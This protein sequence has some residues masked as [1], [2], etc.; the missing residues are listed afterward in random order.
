MK[1]IHV[2][3]G[4][5]V[6][7][8]SGS[9]KAGRHGGIR[10]GAVLVVHFRFPKLLAVQVGIGQYQ[11]WVVPVKVGGY[12]RDVLSRI[13]VVH[14]RIGFAGQVVDAGTIRHDNVA[15][16]DDV[17]RGEGG[18]HLGDEVVD[19]CPAHDAGLIGRGKV[20]LVER[21]NADQGDAVVVSEGDGVGS[22]VIGVGPVTAGVQ[23]APVDGGAVAFHIGRRRPFSG[24]DLGAAHIPLLRDVSA[25]AAS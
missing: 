7:D 17:L 1:G 19:L 18:P 5:R 16:T 13:G 15:P 24:P 12:R 6:M 11:R 14:G 23:E 22:E 9:P 4:H 2:R 10:R 20:R 8:K 21:R 25:S 3:I